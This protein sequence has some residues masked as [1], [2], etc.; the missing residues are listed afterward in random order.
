MDTARPSRDRARRSCNGRAV[1]RRHRDV[2]DRVYQTERARPIF[3]G[4]C[5]N[6]FIRAA[7][8]DAR[9]GVV[10]TIAPLH[11]ASGRGIHHVPTLVGTITYCALFLALRHRHSLRLL[12]GLSIAALAPLYAIPCALG[13]MSGATALCT[14]LLILPESGRSAFRSPALSASMHAP[15]TSDASYRECALT[16]TCPR[17]GLTD[18]MRSAVLPNAAASSDLTVPIAS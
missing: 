12:A 7:C 3:V 16:K 5:D 13:Y 4:R 6:C 8:S 15:R 14:V 1:F 2:L 10:R 17:H 11:L 9:Y 18:R